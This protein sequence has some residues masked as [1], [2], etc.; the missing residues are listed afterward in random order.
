MGRP[1]RRGTLLCLSLL[2]G[3]LPVIALAYPASGASSPKGK[4]LGQKVVIGKGVKHNLASAAKVMEEIHQLMFKGQFTPEQDSEISKMMIR[5]GTMMQ[6]MSGP[7]RE[8]LAPKH[9]QELRKIRHQLEIIK[10]SV[11]KGK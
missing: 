4:N 5:L 7:E 8:K 3:T 9:E 10:Q 1:W 2:I 11:K 6:E